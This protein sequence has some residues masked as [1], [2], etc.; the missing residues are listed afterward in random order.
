M[1]RLKLRMPCTALLQTRISVRSSS[2]KLP[3]TQSVV[4]A[5]LA[6]IHFG[7]ETHPTP[8]RLHGCPASHIEASVTALLALPVP[9]ILRMPGMT[10]VHAAVSAPIFPSS[11]VGTE[12][13]IPA[14]KSAPNQGTKESKNGMLGTMSSANG[15]R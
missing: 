11:G 1:R 5:S 12:T 9:P 10:R 3:P 7:V 15:N 6:Q 14:A 2:S 4:S 13:A 8:P